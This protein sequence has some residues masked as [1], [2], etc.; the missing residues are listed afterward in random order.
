MQK[1]KLFNCLACDAEMEITAPEEQQ[2]VACRQCGRVHRLTYEARDQAW[3]LV[4]EEPAEEE[5]AHQ[6]GDEPFSVAVEFHAGAASR[7][8]RR[9]P[10]RA[11]PS[12][13][14]SAVPSRPTAR[15]SSGNRPTSIPAMKRSS[16]G[17]TENREDRD[18][19]P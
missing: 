15:R 18:D 17:R 11:W 5:T 13:A 4:A 8:P 10:K 19:Q 6:P 16:R 12:R 9:P 2:K 14:R 7:P 1:R 3:L